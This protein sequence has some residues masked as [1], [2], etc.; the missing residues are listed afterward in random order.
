MLG[1]GIQ[2]GIASWWGQGSATDGRIPLLLANAGDTFK[3]TLYYE[4]EGT[5]DPT[6]AQ[7]QADLDYILAN[8]A[9]SPAFL[10]VN[11]K[12]V[13][14][15]YASG[16]DSCS[17]AD[18]WVQ[19]NA[20]RFYVVLKVFSGFR[21]C[22]S[23]PDSWHQYGPAVAESHQVGYSFTISPGFWRIDEASPR[24]ARDPQTWDQNVRDM[25]A[26]G[27]PWQLISTWNEYGEGTGVEATTQFGSTYLDILASP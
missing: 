19:A 13:I 5:G 8:Y 22:A 11:G 6:V 17:M 12:P 2:A 7:I 24:L 3:W 9:S 10:R 4:P 27:E 1:A 21:T 15:V 23:Q 16:T 20:G 18:R 25:V 26:S 14:F